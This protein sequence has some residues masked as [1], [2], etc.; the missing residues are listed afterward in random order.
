MYYTGLVPKLHL[1]ARQQLLSV[2][3]G[4]FERMSDSLLNVG[5]IGLGHIATNNHLPGLLANSDSV[6][7]KAICDA[8]PAA[9]ARF[10]GLVPDPDTYTDH[11]QLLE[12]P[13][14]QAVMLALPNHLHREVCQAAAAAGPSGWSSSPSTRS[15]PIGWAATEERGGAPR[16][17]TASPRKECAS[18]RRSRRH[19][20]LSPLTPR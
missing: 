2:Q 3:R 17:W 7:L 5:F 9:V 8:D 13:E 10:K 6:R 11:Q 16:R 12:D 20:S 18:K 19:R 14:I 15:G 4:G 1:V